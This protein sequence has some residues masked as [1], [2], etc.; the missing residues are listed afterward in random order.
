VQERLPIWIGGNSGPALRR[1][2]RFDGWSA[3][4]TNMEGMTRTPDD[5]ARSVET[6]RAH[7][8]SDGF[9]VAVMGH[10]DQAEPEAFARAGATWW[11][12]NVH[13]G[14]GTPDEMRALVRA[15]PPA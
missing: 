12:E 10:A 14:R 4:T 7:G 6:L 1:A 2:A 3:D 11:L 9:D 8:A 13:D 15:G 5:V